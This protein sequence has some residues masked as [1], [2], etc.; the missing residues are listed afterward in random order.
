MRSE[1]VAN[2]SQFQRSTSAEV[3]AAH[4]ERIHG[5]KREAVRSQSGVGGDDGVRSHASHNKGS[6]S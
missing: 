6:Q 3:Q 5:A 2:G 4:V 1:V